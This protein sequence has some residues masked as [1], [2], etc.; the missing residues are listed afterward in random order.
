MREKRT[1]AKEVSRVMDRIAIVKKT[2]KY[3]GTLC[4]IQI[5]HLIPTLE[6]LERLGYQCEQSSWDPAMTMIGWS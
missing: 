3:N 6:L 5:E 4:T 1:L 2:N